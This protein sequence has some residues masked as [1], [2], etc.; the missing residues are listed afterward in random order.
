MP[1]T[2][3]NLNVATVLSAAI[4]HQQK[5]ELQKAEVLCQGILKEYPLHFDTLQLLG[6][7]G[8]R[9]GNNSAAVKHWVKALKQKPNNVGILSNIGVVY[10]SLGNY[11]EAKQAF[12]KALELDENNINALANYGNLLKN[13]GE[14]ESANNYYNRVI[15]LAPNH[16]A[17]LSNMASIANL[18]QKYDLAEELSS[19]AISLD[20]KHENAL[21]NRGLSY[22]R[23]EKFKDALD[24]YKQVLM[25]NSHHILALNNMSIIFLRIGRDD[26]ALGL[27][28]VAVKTKPD[29]VSSLNNLSI[30]YRETNNIVRAV[31]F[32]QKLIKLSPNTELLESNL[33]RTFIEQGNLEGASKLYDNIL[34][35]RNTLSID[36][37]VVKVSLLFNQHQYHSVITFVDDTCN[38]FSS[39]I[40]QQKD[41]LD[42]DFWK[43][44][45]LIVSKAIASWLIFDIPLLE[46]IL[47]ENQ[48]YINF[49]VTESEHKNIN[50]YGNFRHMKAYFNLLKE[51]LSIYKNQQQLFS[52]D[53]QSKTKILMIA[54]SHCFAFNHQKLA[55]NINS[56][57]ESRLVIGAKVWHLIQKGDNQYKSAFISALDS[58]ETGSKVILGFGEIDCRPDEGIFVH[59]K[60]SGKKIKTI[61]MD[62]LDKYIAFIQQETKLRQL[63][64]LIYGVPAPDYTRL[65]KLDDL[66]KQAFF[67]L[68]A[69]FNEYLKKLSTENGWLFIDIYNKTCDL[70]LCSS[71]KMYMEKFHVSPTIIHELLMDENL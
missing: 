38:K 7:L 45:D 3:K 70:E 58:A 4:Q 64:P 39:K 71:G 50:P 43:T 5:G 10:M 15:K 14:F 57:V 32:F 6:L 17:T 46:S 60:K 1:S 47:A 21:F 69:F 16:V 48:Q 30:A 9:C 68:I 13:I 22:E 19:K 33:A 25:I 51:L 29:D 37:C 24:S 54:E 26:D 36:S 66:D 28:E 18:E 67:E 44:I 11:K 2:E 55:N 8:Y 42:M 61:I 62:M 53:Q 23:Q 56:H 27:L 63:T 12:S 49:F 52:N 35:R 40:L 31:D 41:I 20:G 59:H 65:P 34:K